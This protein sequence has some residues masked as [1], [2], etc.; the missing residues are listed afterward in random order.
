MEFKVADF[1]KTFSSKFPLNVSC[2]QDM[3]V[4]LTSLKEFV[5]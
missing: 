3:Q 1:Q 2:K 4:L 5:M